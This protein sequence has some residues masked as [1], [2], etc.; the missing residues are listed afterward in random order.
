MCMHNSK[1]IESK[2]VPKYAY[3]VYSPFPSYISTDSILFSC[4][5]LKTF[6]KRQI[7][8]INKFNKSDTRKKNPNSCPNYMQDIVLHFGRISVFKNKT[9]AIR[10]CNNAYTLYFKQVWKVQIKQTTKYAYKGVFR[11]DKTLAVDQVKPI[12]MVF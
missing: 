6:Y 3:K 4:K 9:D 1:R 5:D 2:E 8:Q 12:K 7:H 10:F 11:G